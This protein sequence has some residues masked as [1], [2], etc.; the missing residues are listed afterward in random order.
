MKR[1]YSEDVLKNFIDTWGFDDEYVIYGT[2]TTAHSLLKKLGSRL[3]VTAFLDSNQEMLGQLVE[4][5]PV[6]SLEE[7]KAKYRN[8]RIIV[9]SGAYTEIRDRLLQ[10]GLQEQKDFCDSRYLVGCY[11]A[12]THNQ[13]YL[14]RTDITITECCNLRC[15]KCNMLMPYYQEPKH[16]SLEQLKED[17][18]CFFRW[19]DNLQILNL[20]GG[21]PFLYPHV[22]EITRYICEKYADKIEQ[23]FFFTNGL[24]RLTDSMLKVIRQ[25]N[26][27]IQISDY[28]N[29]I[30]QVAGRL[31]EFMR[32][33]E[34]EH[35]AYRRNFDNQWLDF[36]FPDY[37]NDTIGEQDLIQFFDKCYSPF[38]GLNNKKLYYCH[39]NTSAV[40]AGL[41]ED[42]AN[43]Y[44]NLAEYDEERKKDL[45]LFDLGCTEK[46]YITY[47]RR[48]KG[49]FAVNEEY[50]AVA[51]Q[52]AR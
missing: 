2:S 33:L 47:C 26:I 3:R 10:E 49:C 9:A 12:V 27:Q 48:C 18:D 22:E 31:D 32:K 19:V 13:V 41:F 51:E 50:T 17:V 38:R 37:R 36:G 42:N 23:I 40:C 29:G 15:K 21:E 34:D 6:I 43:D 20:L 44:F 52:L 11:F 16:K 14:Y 35:I 45:V 46:G 8:Q 1:H 5:C 24:V 30:P 7:W 28:R 39:L 25:Y 4:G